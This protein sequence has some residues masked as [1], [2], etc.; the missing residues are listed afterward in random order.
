M[1]RYRVLALLISFFST[2]YVYG[3]IKVTSTETY[4]QIGFLNSQSA[5][6][7]SVGKLAR[8]DY[9]Y[10]FMDIGL[11]SLANIGLGLST[12]K[13]GSGVNFRASAG[14]MLWSTSVSYNLKTTKNDSLD[15]GFGYFRTYSTSCPDDEFIC[16]K[17]IDFFYP[18]FSL[19]HKWK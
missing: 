12:A 18:V 8:T 7:V 9:L 10:A 1:N 17:Y 4:T 13:D 3:D 6:I 2:S 19:H 5:Q 11:L 16:I 15:L 14:L